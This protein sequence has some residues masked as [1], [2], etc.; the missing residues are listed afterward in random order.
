VHVSCHRF[1][2]IERRGAQSFHYA[3]LK[4]DKQGGV[5]S[6]GASHF[7]CSRGVL[8]NFGLRGTVTVTTGRL[9]RRGLTSFDIHQL[10]RQSLIVAFFAFIRVKTTKPSG[11]N[12]T[13]TI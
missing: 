10:R 9:S 2:A 7:R 1:D 3:P 4:A 11:A 12:A 13:P 6:V 5:H 8:L